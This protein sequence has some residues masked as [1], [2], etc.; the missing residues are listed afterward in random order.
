[1]TVA[2]DWFILKK[3]WYFRFWMDNC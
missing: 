3:G 1:L 2:V